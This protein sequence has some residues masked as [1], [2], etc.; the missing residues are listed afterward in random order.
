MCQGLPHAAQDGQQRVGNLIGPL[1]CAA[2]GPPGK[3]VQLGVEAMRLGHL[4]HRVDLVLED[5]GRLSHAVE[6]VEHGRGAVL[7]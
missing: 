1:P 6:E 4:E 5:G 3:Q 2:S 7:G